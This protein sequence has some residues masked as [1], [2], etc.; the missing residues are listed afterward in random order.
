MEKP[1]KRVLDYA[2]RHGSR[3]T[4]YGLAST[5]LAGAVL[6]AP[7]AM[8]AGTRLLQ[9]VYEQPLGWTPVLQL[10][11]LVMDAPKLLMIGIPIAGLILGAAPFSLR[12]RLNSLVFL[13]VLVNVAGLIAAIG[14]LLLRG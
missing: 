9:L 3:G 6:A 1:M 13:G 4:A 14:A 10:D 8:I 2:A 11:T 7:V 12:T 5:W